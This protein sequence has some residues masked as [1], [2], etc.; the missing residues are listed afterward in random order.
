MLIEASKN[1]VIDVPM[2]LYETFVIQEKNGFNS[3]TL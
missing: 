1:K 2:Q 3:K